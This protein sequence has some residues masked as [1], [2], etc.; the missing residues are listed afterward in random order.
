MSEEELPVEKTKKK[1]P[2]EK[3]IRTV[4]STKDGGTKVLEQKGK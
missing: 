4:V 3:V 1:E 2:K